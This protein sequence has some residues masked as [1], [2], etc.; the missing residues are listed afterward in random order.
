M[1]SSIGSYKVG[2]VECPCVENIVCMVP[3]FV[4]EKIV[5]NSVLGVGVD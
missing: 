2:H 1:V 5:H 3:E 4:V